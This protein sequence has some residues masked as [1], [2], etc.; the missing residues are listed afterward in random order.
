MPLSCTTQKR[1]N[2]KAIEILKKELTDYLPLFMLFTSI[3]DK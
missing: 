2:T 1:Y 3:F